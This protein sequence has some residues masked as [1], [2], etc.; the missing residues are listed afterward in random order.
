L[1]SERSSKDD[2]LIQRFL[3]CAPEP[4]I[5][6]SS[7]IQNAPEP[8]A[9]LGCIF[10]FILL[11]NQE[12]ITYSLET[13]AEEKFCKYFDEFREVV[14]VAYRVDPFIR[15]NILSISFISN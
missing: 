7:E 15:F 1:K 5:K 12:N 14:E 4:V 9:E 13:K 3:L 6:R 11:A 10:M 2:G 8:K